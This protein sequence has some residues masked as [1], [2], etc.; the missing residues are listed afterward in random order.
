VVPAF[1]TMLMFDLSVAMGWLHCVGRDDQPE[2]KSGSCW[3]VF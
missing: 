2:I 3:D 1:L